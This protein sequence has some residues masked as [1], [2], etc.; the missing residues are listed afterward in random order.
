[1]Q[2]NTVT[3]LLRE[4]QKMQHHAFCGIAAA[5]QINLY[6]RPDGTS[7]M[8]QAAA[9]P[10]PQPPEELVNVSLPVSVLVSLLEDAHEAG[11]RA[12]R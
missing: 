9:A 3:T 8:V 6:L 4:L 12:G 1:M 5:G 2:K 11:E 10:H 7:T